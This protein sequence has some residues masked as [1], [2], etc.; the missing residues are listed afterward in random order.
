M[1]SLSIAARR[2]EIM[3]TARTA[4]EDLL[5]FDPARLR[6]SLGTSL[7]DLRIPVQVAPDAAAIVRSAASELAMLLVTQHRHFVPVDD[8]DRVLLAEG[9]AS[10]PTV[11]ATLGPSGGGADLMAAGQLAP[12]LHPALTGGVVCAWMGPGGRGRSLTGLFIEVLRQAF[13]EMD[14]TEGKEETPLIAMLAL[15]S[16]LLGTEERFRDVLPAPPVDRYLRAA[17][18]CGL[19]V[20]ARTGLARA[21]RAAGRPSFDPLLWRLEA[22]LSPGS[23]L[24]GKS[25]S[26]GGATV[27]G[28]E[29]AAVIPGGEDAVTRLALGTDPEAVAGDLM[30][31]LTADEELARRAEAAVAVG[32][33]RH[34]LF[35]GIAAAEAERRGDGLT[36]LR[37][38]FTAPGA[39]PSI[40]L[41]DKARREV[42]ARMGP[43][44]R[45]G[46]QAGKAL[47]W[48]ARALGDF[49]RRRPTACVGM[50]REA[51]HA[52]Y[53]EA[54]I[55]LTCDVALERL[56]QPA[57][58]TLL[59]RTGAEAEG[60]AD[61]EWEEG[62]LYRITARAGPIL[63]SA[64]QRPLGHLFADVKDFTRRTALL[65]RAPMAEFLRT[66]FY[67]PILV[68]ARGF[69]AGMPHL[70]DR[71]GISV[72]N[73]LGDAISFSGDI[74][75]MVALALEIRR[76]L[77]SYE[78]RLAKQVSSEAVARQL[79]GLE[80]RYQADL[81]RSERSLAAA[82]NSG[83]PAAEIAKLEEEQARIVRDS[84]LALARAR[85]EGIEAGVFISY[86]PAPVT[87]V[88]DDELFGYN[89][90]AIAE[91]INESARGTARAP[92]AR[93][94]ADAA[95]AAEQSAARKP[96][97]RHAWSVFIEPPLAIDVPPGLEQA[98]L[99]AARAGDLQAALRYL[100]AP[101]REAL[102]RAVRA[103]DDAPGGIFNSGAAL[104]EDALKS[105][106]DAVQ[107][108]RHLRR[109]ALAPGDIPADLR[110]QWFYGTAPLE[111][112]ATFHQDGRPAELF[113]RVGQ[114]AFKG[115]GLVV[116]WEMA[117]DRGGP[118]A[119]FQRM[120]KG[121]LGNR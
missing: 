48:V 95:L 46:A 75:A 111:L 17:T 77:A 68:A 81:A 5:R 21:L 112:I 30:K 106:L 56:F 115:L 110:S 102:E 83:A 50:T 29:L 31:A 108:A 7:T 89:R 73:L 67:R 91:K 27:Y 70:A 24:G 100:G 97:L 39:L 25:T 4:G 87:V 79:A 119:L 86:G 43:H 58:R 54:A 76:L 9:Y 38:V 66:E 32:Q 51:A 71:G 12:T 14:A 11:T 44:V 114:A 101:V 105:Y 20:A 80:S 18:L 3:A 117:D 47:E 82:R 26:M 55:A 109:L 6:S 57:R 23:L 103:G 8:L 2:L 37:E 118:G 36:W 84:E 120:G 22:V 90:V 64:A 104:S 93:V 15:F 96:G 107:N 28:C 116:V 69:F 13:R 16:E 10:L 49:D 60:G 19:W 40:C 42:A 52:E 121:W 113:R 88:I 33:I 62:R 99:A 53:A 94:R 98:A 63:K 65:G 85:G 72:N 45:L 78:A 1:A 34:M 35:T 61:A 92:E 74:E 59:V 41:D